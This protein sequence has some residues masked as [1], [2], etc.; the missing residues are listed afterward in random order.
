MSDEEYLSFSKSLPESGL[1]IPNQDVVSTSP[2]SGT[3]AT[4]S[5]SSSPDGGL[6]KQEAVDVMIRED[7]ERERTCLAKVSQGC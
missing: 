1:V 3:T 4:T 6:E 2:D 7:E 5:L